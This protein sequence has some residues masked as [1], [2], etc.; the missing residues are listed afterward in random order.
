MASTLSSIAM[1]KNQAT[2]WLLSYGGGVFFVV[3]LGVPA[4]ALLAASLD[5]L[6]DVISIIMEMNQNLT[7]DL[8]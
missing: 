1:I 6:C 7:S 4:L 2:L 8:R 3:L 5:R